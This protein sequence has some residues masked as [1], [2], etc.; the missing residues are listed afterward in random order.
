MLIIPLEHRPDWRNP[1]VLTVFLIVINV[2]VY[3]GFQ[4][5][6]PQR[7]A[8]AWQWY[9]TSQLLKDERR[10]FLDYLRS[11]D[12][13]A[14]K[15]LENAEVNSGPDAIDDEG[16]NCG[17]QMPDQPDQSAQ[18]Q[19]EPPQ[20]VEHDPSPMDQ[21]QFEY[22]MNNIGYRGFI[23]QKM[24]GN[25]DWL[26]ANAHF[27]E[28]R[29]KISAYAYGFT[30]AEAHWYNWFT[31]LFLHMNL[32]HLLGNMIFLFI[33]GFSL[34]I[35]I[36]RGPMLLL[37]LLSGMGGDLLDW[38]ARMHSMIPSLGASGA[39]SGLMGMYIAVYGL[40]KIN[41]FY[42]LVFYA[43]HFRAP[44]LIVFPVWVGYE[45]YGAVRATD[46]IGH[47][48]HSGG[49]L[50]GFVLLALWLRLGLQYNRD[51]VEKIDH[52]A[53]WK[54]ALA[55]LEEL[56]AAMRLGEARQHGM[57]LA[58]AY[59]RVPQVWQA[60]Y[61]VVKISP[62]SREYHQVTHDLLKQIRYAGQVPELKPLIEQVA[63]DYARHGEEKTPAFTESVAL[64]LAQRI[65]RGDNIKLFVF[66]VD[67]LLALKSQHEAMPSILQVAS[68]L[69]A[70]NGD[71]NLARLYR[72]TL[73]RN[74]P[75]SEA[76]RQMMG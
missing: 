75:G 27:N 25:A 16:D 70:K 72:E 62:S 47:W 36:G 32:E 38:A 11:T 73:L 20:I 49:L 53:P 10:P 45:V 51:F 35:A 22:A 65:N 19:A 30:P 48:V 18:T 39:I 15:R 13:A 66:L 2:L 74:F 76:A 44:A 46:H 56:V 17:C 28:L 26:K 64:E 61:D 68:N 4:G 67:R 58:T 33:F 1:P 24:A 31:S 34:E 29:Q 57:Q 37:Y 40:R 50:F 42:S 23:Q 41:F 69:T 54:K 55:R 71:A 59:P 3:F 5:K 52:D 9:S 63:R 7:E 21:A 12:P 43:G 6:D 8:I 60:L 14:W